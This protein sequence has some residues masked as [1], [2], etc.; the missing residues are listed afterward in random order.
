MKWI[1]FYSYCWMSIRDDFL[2]LPCCCW[3]C[4]VVFRQKQKQLKWKNAELF[5]RTHIHN[6]TKPAQCEWWGEILSFRVHWT[7][8]NSQDDDDDND[9]DNDDDD[10]KKDELWIFH[11]TRSDLIQTRPVCHNTTFNPFVYL[12]VCSVR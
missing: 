11:E 2:L 5:S 1:I 4:A 12:F 3:Y 10:R 9:N 6:V 8:N 7:M